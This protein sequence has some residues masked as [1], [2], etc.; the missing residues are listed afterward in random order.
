MC[1]LA[2]AYH[3]YDMKALR[4]SQIAVLVSGLGANSRVSKKRNGIVNELPDQ[5]FEAVLI[6]KLTNVIWLL[7]DHSEREYPPR[8]TDWIFGK[9]Q[10]QD[11]AQ[12]NVRSFDSQ[13]DFFKARYGGN[14]W[15]KESN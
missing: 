11:N 12:K 15:Q 10:Q 7:A 4:P 8:I 1:D 2:E 5:L 9:D 13:E 3:L 14:K 6:D